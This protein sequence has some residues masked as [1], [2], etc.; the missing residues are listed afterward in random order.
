MPK[1]NPFERNLLRDP[2]VRFGFDNYELLQAL[3][4]LTRQLRGDFTPTASSIEAGEGHEFPSVV[5]L[6]RLAHAAGKRLVVRLEDAE[7]AGDAAHVWR[8]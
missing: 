5:T 3:G 1:S 7:G 4:A 2:D 6:A 8:F